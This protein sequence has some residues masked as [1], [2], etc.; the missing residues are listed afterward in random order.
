M[1]PIKLIEKYKIW[2]ILAILVLAIMSIIKKP[3]FFDNFGIGV[4]IFLFFSSMY[5]LTSKKYPE[6]IL[7]SLSI[8]GVAG[9]VVDLIQILK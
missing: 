6:W 2:I 9:C 5:M 3:V 1:K 4:F 7:W 8:I